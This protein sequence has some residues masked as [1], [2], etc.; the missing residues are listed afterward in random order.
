MLAT[1][2]YKRS[3]YAFSQEDYLPQGSQLGVKLR[4]IT[5]EDILQTPSNGF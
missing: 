3:R 4:Y 2:S 5:K 1:P